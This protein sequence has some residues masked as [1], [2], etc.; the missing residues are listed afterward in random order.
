M[1]V[2]KRFSN[3]N[4]LLAFVVCDEPVV[5][6]DDVEIPLTWAM[7]VIQKD[8][9]YLL[10]H[11]F[12]RRQWECAGGGI[13][14]GETVAQTAIREALEET[15]QHVI[16]LRCHGVFKLKLADSGKV[17]YGALFSATIAELQPFIVNNESDRLTF[18]HPD[19]GITS[20]DDRISELSAWM[21][22]YVI[23]QGSG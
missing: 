5:P 22:D 14:P 16:D 20:L 4:E 9:R 6:V 21:I 15:S 8:G 12:N 23:Q 1:A 10:Q 19:E 13:E 11:N 18:W 3:G 7:T 2:V 17:E